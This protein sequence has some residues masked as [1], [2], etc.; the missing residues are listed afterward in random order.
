MQRVIP[1]PHS[2]VL[3]AVNAQAPPWNGGRLRRRKDAARPERGAGVQPAHAAL[4]DATGGQLRFLV[5]RKG[6]RICSRAG[7]GSRS[8]AAAG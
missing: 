6:Q 1:N 4:A 3:R 8:T 5:A 2:G 7:G